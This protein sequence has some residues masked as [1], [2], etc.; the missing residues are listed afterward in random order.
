MTKNTS[1]VLLLLLVAVLAGCNQANAPNST[2]IQQIGGQRNKAAG[3]QQ[4]IA[5][6]HQEE[7]RI[8]NERAKLAE[9]RAEFERQ[10]REHAE[11]LLRQAQEGQDKISTA[12]V[13]Q[14]YSSPAP[15]EYAS[16]HTTS[17]QPAS[18]PEFTWLS[19]DCDEPLPKIGEIVEDEE[20]IEYEVI[21]RQG[22]CLKGVRLKES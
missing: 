21:G 3:D 12:S 15:R 14:A 7:L 6:N 20:G 11:Q 10:K 18:E 17:Y 9:E 19:W 4:D 1:F 22:Y 2:A 16:H 13:P 8:A 5:A